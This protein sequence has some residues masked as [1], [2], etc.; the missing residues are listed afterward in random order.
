M[1]I[2]NL[3]KKRTND[4]TNTLYI[5]CLD[6]TQQIINQTKGGLK[7]YACSVHTL[8]IPKNNELYLLTNVEIMTYTYTWP[9]RLYNVLSKHMIH[10]F[11]HTDFS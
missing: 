10:V 5:N 8:I 3:P 1:E 2:L 9:L 6:D 7:I 4:Y 11:M